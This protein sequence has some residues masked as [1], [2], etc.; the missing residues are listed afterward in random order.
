MPKKKKKKSSLLS[1]AVES[2]SSQIV[3]SEESPKKYDKF[4]VEAAKTTQ[5]RT[6]A[7]TTPSGA[8]FESRSTSSEQQQKSS[9]SSS[10]DYVVWKVRIASAVSKN[11]S[12][13]IVY[14]TNGNHNTIDLSHDLYEQLASFPHKTRIILDGGIT[15]SFK[16]NGGSSNLSWKNQVLVVFI[17]RLPS[18]CLDNANNRS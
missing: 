7:I 9:D 1:A 8:D 18:L 13:D 14:N 6:I 4:T 16:K 11:T 10:T 2:P 15:K 12:S 5:I 17:N 3:V